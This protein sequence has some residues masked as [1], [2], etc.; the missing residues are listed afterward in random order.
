MVF[1]SISLAAVTLILSTSLN[2]AFIK[3][4]AVITDDVTSLEWLD[5]SVTTNVRYTDALS[6]ANQGYGG[7]WR[8]AIQVEVEQLMREFFPSYSQTN[9]SGD[10]G[11]ELCVEGGCYDAQR[12]Q[13]ADEFYDLF[14][15]YS[16]FYENQF[17]SG[18]NYYADGL[19]ALPNGTLSQYGISPHSRRTGGSAKT[20]HSL[21]VDMGVGIFDYNATYFSR[22]IYLVRGDA[23]VVPI[24]SAVWL[25]GSGLLGLV[26][27]ARRK[28]A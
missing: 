7:G 14:G 4:G 24:P 20:A 21:Q 10:G 12:R 11:Y 17:S 1:K 8:Y 5:L 26:G 23:A 25:F 27:L 28:K 18:V 13:S 19:V 6:V 22:G 2:A 3:N 16:A 9:A 15:T